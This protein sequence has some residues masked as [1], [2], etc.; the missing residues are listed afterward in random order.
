[1]K[2]FIRP[3]N[4]WVDNIDHEKLDKFADHFNVCIS[5]TKPE[6][7]TAE[8]KLGFRLNTGLDG[9]PTLTDAEL[10]IAK[11]TARSNGYLLT[12]A[13]DNYDTTTYTMQIL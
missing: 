3:R 8:G 10:I 11:A 13:D 9:V 2:N 1:M 12:E 6:A 4:E 5:T 7:V